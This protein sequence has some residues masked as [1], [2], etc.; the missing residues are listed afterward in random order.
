MPNEKDVIAS[1]EIKHV[2]MAI[3]SS[4]KFR[5]RYEHP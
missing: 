1:D 4:N 5:R 2:S 3:V